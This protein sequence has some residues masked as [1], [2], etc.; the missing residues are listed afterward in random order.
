MNLMSLIVNGEPC[1]V[2]VAP[3]AFYVRMRF[4][5][6]GF[7]ETMFGCNQISAAGALR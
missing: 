6:L 7:T 3:D 4:Q 5:N 2:E 1:S